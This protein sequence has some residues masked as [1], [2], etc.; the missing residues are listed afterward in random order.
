MV[1]ERGVIDGQVKIVKPHPD[2]RIF[3]TMDPENGEISRAMRNRG[4]EIN[5]LPAT[6]A[7]SESDACILLNKVGIPG[8]HI[9]KIMIEFH[10]SIVRTQHSWSENRLGIRELLRWATLTVSLLQRGHFFDLALTWSM[11]QVY[12]RNQRLQ[13]TQEMIQN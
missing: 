7:S 10:R 8:S 2:F 9:P 11:K 1:N 3:V 5:L 4:I 13:S 6:S 12:Q